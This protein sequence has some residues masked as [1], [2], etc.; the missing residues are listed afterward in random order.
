MKSKSTG[1]GDKAF[2]FAN[3]FFLGFILLIF[4]YPAIY[5]VSCSF[6]NAQAVVTGKVFLWPVKPTL[7][8]YEAIFQNK[9]IM[10]GYGNTIFYTVVGTLLSVTLTM[11]AAFPLSQRSFKLGTPLMMIFAFT[12]YFGGGI[13]PT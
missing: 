3:Y 7:K 5:I 10:S 8:G 11:L 12:M 4:I 13:I 6:S 1:L 2:Y 9:D